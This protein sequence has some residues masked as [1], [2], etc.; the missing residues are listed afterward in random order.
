MPSS[1]RNTETVVIHGESFTFERRTY[2]QPD[3]SPTYAR[4]GGHG[5]KDMDVWV[6]ATDRLLF[7]EVTSRGAVKKHY[8]GGDG[9]MLQG[10]ADD[11]TA[12]AIHTLLMLGAGLTGVEPSSSVLRAHPVHLRG[13]TPRFA[14]IVGL[15]GLDAAGVVALKD[16][17]L[18]K[19]GPALALWGLGA[20]DVAVMTFDQARRSDAFPY[21]N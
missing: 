16:L 12:R 10:L 1:R 14:F 11:L 8:S 13:L 5:V 2:F 7:I 15:G 19:L 21:L 20:G 17:L 4:L 18:L 3:G 6:A 9:G